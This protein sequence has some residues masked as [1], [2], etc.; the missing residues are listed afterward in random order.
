MGI[1]KATSCQ[2]EDLKSCKNNKYVLVSPWA[3]ST[4]LLL[5]KTSVFPTTLILHNPLAQLINSNFQTGIPQSNLRGMWS[6]LVLNQ[7][8][9]N[10]TKNKETKSMN[11]FVQ[12]NIT[13]S[14]HI[15]GFICTTILRSDTILDFPRKQKTK[16]WDWK[17]LCIN[18]ELMGR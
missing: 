2:Q 16:T 5:T 17:S 11:P 9:K 3:S 7:I 12:R 15:T 14:K 4:K 8:T 13:S 1:F 10:K 18:C 6:V